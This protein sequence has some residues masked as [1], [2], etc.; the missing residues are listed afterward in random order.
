MAALGMRRVRLALACALLALELAGVVR[1]R[2]VDTRW[3]CWAPHNQITE[4]VIEARV[5]E[6]ALTEGEILTRYRLPA[7]G[8]DDRCAFNVLEIVRLAEE[9]YHRTDPA[10]VTVIFRVNGH[11]PVEWR[12]P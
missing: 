5:G 2:F 1:A 9:R 10:R 8:L 12:Y 7:R 11:P 6:K 3:F 4:Y